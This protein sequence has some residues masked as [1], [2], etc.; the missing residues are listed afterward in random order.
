M[1]MDLRRILVLPNKK[2]FI[3]LKKMQ[4]GCVSVC[5]YVSG[6]CY[7]SYLLSHWKTL[8]EKHDKRMAV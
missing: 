2:I 7:F 6:P 3:D 8:G 1:S 4:W 5:V